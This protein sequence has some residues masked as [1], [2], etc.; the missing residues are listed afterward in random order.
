[1]GGVHSIKT[2][3]LLN[4]HLTQL[5]VEVKNKKSFD[6]WILMKEFKSKK[7]V[8]IDNFASN[9]QNRFVEQL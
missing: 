5:L 3:M 2:L 6:L 1:M 4:F 7:I 8:Q 9:V